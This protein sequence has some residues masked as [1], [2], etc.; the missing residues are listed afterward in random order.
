MKEKLDVPFSI[1][2]SV[3]SRILEWARETSHEFAKRISYY[4]C[5]MLRAEKYRKQKQLEQSY[6]TLAATGYATLNDRICY[7]SAIHSPYAFLLK[8]LRKLKSF[9][10]R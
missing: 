3:D 6:Q 8:L 10:D 1:Q 9:T 5:A 2:T 4:R 7:Y